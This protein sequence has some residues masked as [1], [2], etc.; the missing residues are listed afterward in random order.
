MI[1]RGQLAKSCKNQFLWCYLSIESRQTVVT[2]TNSYGVICLSSQ[3][4]LLSQEPI[5]MVL[6]VYR[7]KADCCHKNQFFWCYL[8]IE[9]GQTVVTRTNS[10]GVICLSSLSSQGKLLSQEPILLVLFVYRVR[11]DRCHKKQFL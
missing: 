5:L 6:F 2:R 9:S 8:S 3:G 10:Y 4:R 7:V 1:R 11:A